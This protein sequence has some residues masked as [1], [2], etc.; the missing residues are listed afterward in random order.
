MNQDTSQ[1][2]K[3]FLAV[4]STTV[5]VDFSC[6]AAMLWLSGNVPLAKSIGFCIGTLFAYLANRAWTFQ[7]RQ[8]TGSSLLP[9]C[10]IYGT[11]LI[12][13]VATNQ[14]LL[15]LLGLGKIQ[16]LLAFV[17]ATGISA[18]LNFLGMK[19]FVFRT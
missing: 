16:V 3:R 19:F 14:G 18:T 7:G 13:N 12:I 15:W 6:Y 1:Q 4:G 17:I 8:S 10:A 5:V 11:T 9:F 2:V